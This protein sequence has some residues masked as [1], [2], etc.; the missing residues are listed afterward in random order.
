MRDFAKENL[1]DQRLARLEVEL[2][3]TIG[4]Q[5]L[6]LKAVAA[7]IEVHPDREQVRAALKPMIQNLN[8]PNQASLAGFDEALKHVRQALGPRPDGP[9]S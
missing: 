3:S 8:F 2:A 7:L 1:I 4:R 6:L 5:E 9:T